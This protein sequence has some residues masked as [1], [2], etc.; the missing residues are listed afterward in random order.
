MRTKPRQGFI[1]VTVLMISVVL[2]LLIF[3]TSL[4]SLTDRLAAAEH[5][6]GTEAYY[7]AQAGLDRLKTGAFL[8]LADAYASADP[9]QCQVGN[10]ITIDIGQGVTLAPGE[11]VTLGYGD[12]NHTLSYAFDDGRFLLTSVGAVGR[13]ESTIQVVATAGLGPAGVWENAVYTQALDGG[14][15]GKLAGRVA[16][17]GS[18]HIVSGD[19]LIGDDALESS[20]AS[21]VFNNY[22]GRSSGSQTSA[23]AEAAKAL[24]ATRVDQVDD[25]CAQLKIES[26]DVVLSGNAGIG[27]AP[28]SDETDPLV[29]PIEGIYLGNDG[30]VREKNSA[31]ALDEESELEANAVYAR[32]GVSNYDAFSG[33]T[34]PPL[35]EVFPNE[36][37]ATEHAFIDGDC[38]LASGGSIVLPP[39]DP[40][41]TVTCGDTVNGNTLTW[42]GSNQRLVIDG[43]VTLT[44]VGFVLQSD[45]AYS[46]MGTVRVAA[47]DS[48]AVAVS[49]GGEIL[50]AQPSDYVS[51]GSTAAGLGIVTN[52]SIAVGGSPGTSPTI[53]AMLY[54]EGSIYMNQTYTVVGSLVGGTVVTEQVPR[55]AFHPGVAAMAETLCLPGSRCDLG[56]EFGD[57]GYF[58]DISV[59]RR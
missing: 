59:E 6:G 21:G 45:I 56:G 7:V 37:T 35:D 12:G 34:F 49:I 5:R 39:A 29:N 8:T 44:D 58:R 52:G 51:S 2:V 9:G 25:L 57:P 15:R 40:T 13:S 20:G 23:I 38:G 28:V 17:Y 50:P 55:V 33:L 22:Y 14:S 4:T 24:G 42:D 18:V 48:S 30:V 11:S 16:A 36:L 3:T 53:A 46:G 19:A 54:A 47:T 41:I 43:T 31:T 1:L 32:S 27:E 26:G 10:S